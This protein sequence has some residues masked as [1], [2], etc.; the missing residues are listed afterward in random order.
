MGTVL[1][2]GGEGEGK[3][4]QADGLQTLRP[5]LEGVHDKVPMA[6]GSCKKRA[7]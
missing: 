7:R 6:C 4:G 5:G 3:V 1:G 2:T